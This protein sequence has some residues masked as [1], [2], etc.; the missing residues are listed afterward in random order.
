MVTPR[1]VQTRTQ[2]IALVDAVAYL[3]G[4]AGHGETVGRTFEIGGPDV[5][6][7]RDMLLT[8]AGM[9]GRRRVIVPVPVL[10]PRLS[11]WWL[12]LI[13][14]VDLTTARALVDSMTNEVVVTDRSIEDLIDHRPMS[15]RAAAEMAL[16]DRAARLEDGAAARPD[17]DA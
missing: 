14:D 2:P 3:A 7:Y 17:P 12:R 11:S 1:W 9:T 15:F 8:V 10:S 16:A 6:T 13:T 4:V 5:L